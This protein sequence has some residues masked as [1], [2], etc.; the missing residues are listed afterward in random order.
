MGFVHGCVVNRKKNIDESGGG[1]S[2]REV[3][4]AL[5]LLRAAQLNIQDLDNITVGMLFDILTENKNDSYDYP[6]YATADDI[7]NLR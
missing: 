2:T 6:T 3:N 7:N 1:Q 4:T 5:I